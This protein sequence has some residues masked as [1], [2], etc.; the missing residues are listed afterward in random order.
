MIRGSLVSSV[1]EARPSLHTAAE[2]G[3][4]T[5]DIQLGDGLGGKTRDTGEGEGFGSPCLLPL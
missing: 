1:V 2:S 3:R 4:G 5:H